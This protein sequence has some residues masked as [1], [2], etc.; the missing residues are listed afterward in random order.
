MARF[1]VQNFGHHGFADKIFSAVV[2]V[3][4]KKPVCVTW[5]V[6]RICILSSAAMCLL[7]S[8]DSPLMIFCVLMY[9]LHTC[10]FILE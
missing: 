8:E 1:G 5:M 2:Y 3:L 7:Q 10:D 4:P 9:P 6:S